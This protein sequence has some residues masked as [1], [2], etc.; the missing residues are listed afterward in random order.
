MCRPAA[1]AA[2]R[3]RRPV[4]PR[5]TNSRRA[6]GCRGARCPGACAGTRA[7][8]PV[9][10]AM[11]PC[12]TQGSGTESRVGV[13]LLL[14]DGREQLLGPPLADDVDRTPVAQEGIEAEEPLFCRLGL[15]EAQ[16]RGHDEL[17]QV[18]PLRVVR[19]DP[20]SAPPAA[21]LSRADAE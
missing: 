2:P 7:A 3:P 15:V 14:T 1:G 20:L 19:I 6:R 12:P 21:D 9:R 8:R 18:E 5:R 4:P 10:L 17:E 11:R 16:K 13:R